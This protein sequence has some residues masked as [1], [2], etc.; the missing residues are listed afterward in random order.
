MADVSRL[1]PPTISG[2]LPSF[3]PVNGIVNMTIPFSMNSAVSVSEVAGFYLRL[4][5]TTTDTLLNIQS[6]AN[7]DT[8]NMQ[9]TFRLEDSTVRKLIIGNYYKVQIAYYNRTNSGDDY[10]GYYSNA[11]IIKYTNEPS[12]TVLSLNQNQT[13]AIANRTFTGVYTNQDI[14]E[15]VYS[16]RFALSAINDNTSLITDVN[17]LTV[18]KDT[19]WMIH[20]NSNDTTLG[21]SQ[22][23]YTIQDGIQIGKTYELKYGIRTINGLE[24][25]SPTYQIAAISSMGEALDFN[26]VSALDY[27]NG[28]ITV[29]AISNYEKRAMDGIN[30]VGTE[31]KDQIQDREDNPK[32]WQFNGIYQLLRTDNHSNFQDWIIVANLELNNVSFEDYNFSDYT[33][34][35][36]VAYKY[37][38]DKIST[39]GIRSR[40]V[41]TRTSIN[42][43]FE[44]IFLY[45]GAR[46]LRIRYNPNVASFKEIIQETKKTTLGHKYPIILRNGALRY[47]EFPITGLLSYLADNDELFMSK[48]ELVAEEILLNNNRI[49]RERGSSTPRATEFV[50]TTDMTDENI[51]AEKSFS[52]FVLE[53]LNNGKMKLFRSPQEGNYIVRLLNVSLSANAQTGRM[54]HT[55]TCTADEVAPF[56]FENLVEYDLTG[57]KQSLASVS[58]VESQYIVDLQYEWDQCRDRYATSDYSHIPLRIFRDFINLDFSRGR[59]ITKIQVVDEYINQHTTP[60]MFSWN[61]TYKWIVGPSGRYT[62][63]LEEPMTGVL[64]LLNPN[65]G[66]DEVY[67]PEGNDDN[68][69]IDPFFGQVAGVTITITYRAASEARADIV[70]SQTIRT[71][72]GLSQ[73]GTEQIALKKDNNRYYNSFYAYSNLRN[74]VSDMYYWVMHTIPVIENSQWSQ[75]SDQKKQEFGLLFGNYIYVVDEEGHYR[76]LN[77]DGTFNEDLTALDTQYYLMKPST[78]INSN[79]E[80]V[81]E[82]HEE[83]S[84]IT[85]MSSGESYPTLDYTNEMGSYLRCGNGIYSQ[86][87]GLVQSQEYSVEYTEPSNSLLINARNKMIKAEKDWLMKVFNLKSITKQEALTCSLLFIYQDGVFVKISNAD[88]ANYDNTEWFSIYEGHYTRGD[89]QNDYQTYYVALEQFLAY[90]K[91][92]VGD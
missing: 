75:Y 74:T 73:Y 64:R 42:A 65:T 26:L 11:G 82:Y 55:F 24:V 52:Q 32:H 41:V 27:D 77:Q 20:D 29:R 62:I 71:Y 30:F 78:T 63:E 2:T 92:K 90:L 69:E 40:R 28:C 23:I 88:I 48:E 57:V 76:T 6:T 84:D 37:G 50:E 17:R 7:W 10:V 51:L 1:W 67:I 86:W 5:T 68:G 46:Q 14:S 43:F 8:E 70:A 25:W 35:S 36:G 38:M 16:Y 9:V 12:V 91:E 18:V 56:T 33:V 61:D 79:G 19:G 89:I 85:Q 66:G 60:L 87:Y 81:T 45:D 49:D 15:K 53:W 54:L 3:Y 21:K 80:K 31:T 59:A 34:E 13:N 83:G 44:D 47:K 22:D 39:G 4:K 72:Y 58:Y